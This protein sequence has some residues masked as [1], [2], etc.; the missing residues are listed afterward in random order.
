MTHSMVR[1]RSPSTLSEIEVPTSL[2]GHPERLKG[3]EG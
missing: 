1:L 3:V 2:E